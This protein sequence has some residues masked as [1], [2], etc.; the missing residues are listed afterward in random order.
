MTREI[1]TASTGLPAWMQPET[2]DQA[3]AMADRIAASGLMPDHLAGNP[4][5]VLM[6]MD[7]AQRWGMSPLAVAQATSLV[8][9]KLC[10]EGKLIHAALLSQRA[11]REP[12]SYVY[13][14]EG[15]TM[16][17][18]VYG[19]L[20]CGTERQV[21]GTVRDWRTHAKNKSGQDVSPWANPGSWR[22]MLAYRGTREW[23]RMYAPAVMLGVQ[24][25]DEVIMDA[26]DVV[27]HD[28]LS[29]PPPARV[30][31]LDQGAENAVRTDAT[32]PIDGLRKAIDYARRMLGDEE[33]IAVMKPIANRVGVKK[34]S[35][36][37][38]EER[39]T[40]MREIY[41]AVEVAETE[42]ERL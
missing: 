31:R 18:T 42:G 41:E 8:R 35:D 6:I 32:D 3:L 5:G 20:A 24:T 33:A 25:P 11:I 12:L 29:D 7:Q 13:E 28:D 19:T 26:D 21:A 17:V 1:A 30:P 34:L 40:V 9:G 10:Y 36:T 2:L 15:E 23:A 38:E 22:K 37:P 16:K 4:G 39:A 27:V 14:G